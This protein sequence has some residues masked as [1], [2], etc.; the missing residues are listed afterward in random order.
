MIGL[1]RAESFQK[2]PHNVNRLTFTKQFTGEV[3]VWFFV[4]YNNSH[5]DSERNK[6][7]AF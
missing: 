5:P 3:S 1:W 4:F 2:R 7:L 6:Y